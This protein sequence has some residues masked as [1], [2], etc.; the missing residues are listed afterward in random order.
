V[1]REPLDRQQWRRDERSGTSV[2]RPT[3][4]APTV[5]DKTLNL[6]RQIEGA[7]RSGRRQAVPRAKPVAAAEAKP[8]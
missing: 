5:D 7:R 6:W 3:F 4:S 2:A 1:A 8:S